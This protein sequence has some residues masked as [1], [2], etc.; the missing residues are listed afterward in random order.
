VNQMKTVKGWS[1]AKSKGVLEMTQSRSRRAEVASRTRIEDG[2]KGS[3]G[4]ELEEEEMRRTVSGE[5]LPVSC[6]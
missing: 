3:E 4:S 6:R 1:K 5:V 2:Q